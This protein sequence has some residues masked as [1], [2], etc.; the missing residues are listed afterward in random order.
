MT[1][2][3][4]QDKRNKLL[5]DAQAIVLKADVTA[6]DRSTFDTMLADVATVE[7]DIQRMEALESR[8]GSIPRPVPGAGVDETPEA[9][10]KAEKRAFADFVVRG[11]HAPEQRDLTT[12]SNSAGQFVPQAFYPQIIEAMKLWGDM[13]NVVR[14]VES[15]NGAPTKY[16]TVNDTANLFYEVGENTAAATDGSMGTDPTI[17]GGLLSTSM[18]TR[19]PIIVSFAEL[20]DSAFDLD[21]FVKNVIGKSYFRGLSSL[22]VNGST[23]GN[24]GSVLA[25]A[26][27]AVY[28][29]VPGAS[30]TDQT[31]IQYPD[32]TA[33]W[34]KLD[35]AYLP[36]ATWLM[37]NTTKGYLLGV[38]DTLGRPLYIPAP[39]AGAFDTLLGAPV[40]LVQALPNR[41]AGAMPIL[42]GDFEQG[43]LLKTVKPGLAV[44]RLNE[45]YAEKLSVGFVPYARCGGVLTDAGTHPI[46]GMKV[47]AGS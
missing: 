20:Q 45:R 42:F 15:D 9:R 17:A 39:N 34:S 22:I 18:L 29:T 13:V 47:K 36:N 10:A 32:I 21:A 25:L 43:Y 7:A 38:R 26:S 19:Q 28:T 35:P 44:M 12:A 41:V 14:K 27:G 23:S 1:K 6:E 2:K 11:I 5:A 37:N 46:V 24:I 30:D 33:L 8:A 16:A 4:L 31:E 3:E 40:R